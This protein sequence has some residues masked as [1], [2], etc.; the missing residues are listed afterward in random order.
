MSKSKVPSYRRQRKPT[1]D[2]AFVKLDDQ[3]IYLGAYNT[4]ESRELYRKTVA[5]W[6]ANNR[7][8]PADP[9]IW[10]VEM[11]PKYDAFAED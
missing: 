6:L 11:I 9:D 10:I 7:Q 5:E 3:R 4:S 2:L 1:G 8:L